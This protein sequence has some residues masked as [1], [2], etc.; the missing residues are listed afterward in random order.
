MLLGKE[1]S[2]GRNGVT[3]K[4]FDVAEQQN[5]RAEWVLLKETCSNLK[6]AKSRK[7]PVYAKNRSFWP[8]LTGAAA[9]D[10]HTP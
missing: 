5:A 10:R 1:K 7:R 3:D 2:A 6:P 4:D 9:V 8:V